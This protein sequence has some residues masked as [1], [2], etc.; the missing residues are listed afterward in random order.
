MKIKT[1]RVSKQHIKGQ[2]HATFIINVATAWR[3][4]QLDLATLPE[5]S[6]VTDSARKMSVSRPALLNNLTHLPVVL[7]LVLTKHASCF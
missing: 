3:T 1:I 7:T 5:K 4:L 2:F 6:L